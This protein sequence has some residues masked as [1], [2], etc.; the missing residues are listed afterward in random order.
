MLSSMVFLF[1][2]TWGT[3]SAWWLLAC[4]ALG[5]F[6]AWFFYRRQNHLNSLIKYLLSAFR[7]IA[8]TVI[9]L[10]LL[11]PLLKTI[12]RDPQKPLI[13][14]AQDNSSSVS[15]FKSKD[16]NPE[17]FVNQL[18]ELKKDLG[19]DYD[20]REFN[21]SR[22]LKDSLSVKFDGRQTDI[23]AA[24]KGFTERFS[25]QNVGA[26]VLA[27]DGLY[28]KGSSPQYAARDLKTSIY[29]IA[30]G[31]TAPRRD[32]LIGNVNYNKTAFLGNDFEVEVLTEAYQS[33]GDGIRLKVSE[34]GSTVV[35][36]NIIVP[37]TDFRKVIPLKLHADKK[38]IHKFTISLQPV[39][40]EIST[41]NN[42]E[43]F[44][45]EVLDSKQKILLLYNGPHPDISAIK[46]SLESNRNYEVKTALVTDADVAKLSIYSLVI[47]YQLPASGSVL[48]PPLQNQLTK[49]K[50]PLWYIVGA[51]SDIP[52]LNRLQRIL[53]ISGTRQDMQ[54]V[55]TSPKTDFS[56]FTLSDSTRR[57][58]DVLPPLL[59]PFG[60]YSM[61]STP[62]VLLKQRI[63]RVETSYPLLAFGEDAGI[64]IAVLSA[65]GI[66]KWRLAEFS[67]NGNHRAIE[68]LL[69]QSVQ[70]LTA[71][72]DRSRF[73]VYPAKNAF[74][75]SDDV[76]LNAELYNDALE[77]INIPD[78]KI[79][80]KGKSGKT[81]SFIFTRNGNSYQLNAGTL[82]PDEYS[83]HAGAKL[84]DKSFT[85]EGELVVKSV[86][87]E[88]RQSAADHKLLYTL[89][90]ESGGQ[91]LL[92][93]QVNQLAELIRK[94]EGIKTIVYDDET[95]RDLID[96]KL[97]FALILIL[98]S[99][100]WYLRKHE[101]EV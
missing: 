26:L 77:L 89:A 47:L 78:V 2:I 95:Y 32:I 3:V 72:G 58:F 81:F 8:V 49:L 69:S 97:V 52:Q 40:N 39:P 19:S 57:E 22:E 13:I 31:D 99:A 62:F 53:Q 67:T 45:V 55:F 85:A 12:T 100:E 61:P 54:E 28:N 35:S 76:L 41:E 37:S 75:E 18:G 60:N 93:S 4:V 51:Q 33:K 64:R 50:V 92:P 11:S 71:K 30:L 98:L 87:A 56:A 80:L 29:T 7:V 90:K 5:L 16:F 59:A 1:S 84:G 48:P 20:V 36:Q 25:N 43:T 44:Y 66:W 23:S 63:G 70:Y 24:F 74:D 34:D 9:S 96:D 46:L 65:E 21:F 42:I 17:K 86:N 6:Y 73:R 15:L 38:G 14:I 94:N 101:G 91:M 10:L 27:T 83:Y 88:T 79:D 68:E 82:P